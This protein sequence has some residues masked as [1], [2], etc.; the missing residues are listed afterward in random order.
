MSDTYS[1]EVE[2]D[3]RD[4]LWSPEPRIPFT[5]DEDFDSCIINFENLFKALNFEDLNVCNCRSKSISPG[6]EEPKTVP[7]RKRS[8]VDDNPDKKSKI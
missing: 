4:D 1:M 7:K 6:F 8:P 2:M 3:V 5:E